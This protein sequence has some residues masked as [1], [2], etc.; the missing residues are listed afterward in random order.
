M[1]MEFKKEGNEE[2]I[3]LNGIDVTKRIRSKE[4][5][6]IVSEVSRIV[7]LRIGITDLLRKMAEG[8]DVVME[9]RDITTYVFPNAEVKIYLDAKPEERA[10]RRYKENMEKGIKT[11]YEEVLENVIR[12]DTNDKNKKVGA[13]KIADDAI[14]IDTTQ[15]TIEEVVEEI[16]KIIKDRT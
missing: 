12:R 13:L 9:G 8:K 11:S 16:E 6:D 15:K 7:P 14:V 3:F 10:K 5:N 4:V 2:K 1:N